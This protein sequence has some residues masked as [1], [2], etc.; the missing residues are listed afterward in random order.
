MTWQY[1]VLCGSLIVGGLFFFFLISKFGAKIV[2]E[3]SRYDRGQSYKTF[4]DIITSLL[5]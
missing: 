4:F 2:E 5:M 1:W 3:D